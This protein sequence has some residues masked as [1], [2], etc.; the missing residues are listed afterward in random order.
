MMR[1]TQVCEV[2]A[3]KE[4]VAEIPWEGELKP[5]IGV[6]KQGNLNGMKALSPSTAK[7]SDKSTGT[8]HSKEGGS[9]GTW[10][11]SLKYLGYNEQEVITVKP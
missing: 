7:F 10:S 9:E 6:A 1:E 5:E 8:L 3:T 4:A 2:D 11:G